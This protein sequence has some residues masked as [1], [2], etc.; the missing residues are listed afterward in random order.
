MEGK[1][2][3]C[4]CGGPK[5]KDHRLLSRHVKTKKH[6]AWVDEKKVFTPKTKTQRQIEQRNRTKSI[7]FTCVCGDVLNIR[8]KLAHDK[9]LRHTNFIEN[10]NTGSTRCACGGFY[11]PNNKDNHLRTRK[12]IKHVINTVLNA[13]DTGD[14]FQ[15]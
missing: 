11:K 6:Q 13:E 3:L 9:T 14:N 10:R 12:H 15:N 4:G 8:S 5:P 7:F 2:E 1:K